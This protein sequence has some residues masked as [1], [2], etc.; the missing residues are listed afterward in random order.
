MKQTLILLIFLAVFL[1]G[2]SQPIVTRVVVDSATGEP[3]P[4]A[5]VYL[6]NDRRTGTLTNSDGRFRLPFES[7]TDSLVISHLTYLAFKQPI[8]SLPGDTLR[9]TEKALML[10]E[11]SIYGE[12]GAHFF[13]KIM[14]NLEKNHAVEPALY[15]VF[16][17]S[18]HHETDLSALH[19]LSEYEMKVYF[20]TNHKG[21]L[22]IEHARSRPF[23]KPGEAHSSDLFV[24]EAAGVVFDNLFLSELKWKPSVFKR[25]TIEIVGSTQEDDRTLLRLDLSPVRPARD[26]AYT[27]YM[28]EKSFAVVRLITY[29]N[30]SQ[31]AFEELRYRELN[32]KWYLAYSQNRTRESDFY[33]KWDT[34]S[35]SV[36]EWFALFTLLPLEPKT[37]EFK[38]YMIV[39][40]PAKEI[41]G[42]WDDPF[43]D[44]YKNIPLPEWMQRVVEE[45]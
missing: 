21:N 35:N 39:A 27:L 24:M 33:Q 5:Y 41:L 10:E 26:N 8:S 17:R 19:I 15:H 31:T 42:K 16:F 25:F 23:S 12:T 11:V 3:I 2:I 13:Q 34:Q 9:L 37:D 40:Q 29:Y 32:G 20:D 45:K 1:P 28:D 4:Y 38:G 43:W 18:A 22:K 44:Q 6:S 30:E 7:G 36:R 14:D